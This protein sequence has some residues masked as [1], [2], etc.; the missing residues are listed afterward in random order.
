MASILDPVK[1]EVIRLY[2][3]GLTLVEVGRR[4]GVTNTCVRNLLLAQGVQPRTV[5]EASQLAWKKP[6]RV[7]RT[8][9]FDVDQ[10]VELYRDGLDSVEI[11][12]RLGTSS[13]HVRYLLRR[14][15]VEVRSKSEAGKIAW[16]ENRANGLC[17]EADVG[18]YRVIEDRARLA[19]ATQLSLPFDLEGQPSPAERERQRR[20]K[21]E[22][23]EKNREAY[24]RTARE[25]HRLLR[26][27]AI[28]A[29]GGACSCCGSSHSE[30]LAIDHTLG[31]GVRHRLYLGS[32]GIGGGVGFYR[33]LK[34][35]GYPPEFR[36]M[37]HNCNCST[38][39][40]GY[41]PHRESH[42]FVPSCEHL[43]G[44][45]LAKTVR[46]ARRRRLRLE[47]V[48]GYGGRC[49]CCGEDL[50]EFLAVD[51]VA[52]DGAEHRR[53]IGKGSTYTFLRQ[54]VTDGFPERYRLL[55][56]NCN[57]SLGWYGHCP[58]THKS[59]CM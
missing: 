17:R 6:S 43:S 37:C 34:K 42:P 55:C 46:Q 41:C 39:W 9:S 29:Y 19:P 4:F 16:E 44:K 5:G 52:G 12:D 21:H 23:Y 50:V 31:G 18:P 14:S 22:Y 28:A 47:V 36:L 1:D 51:H 53:E 49:A 35:N 27:E 32:R 7:A 3:S 25:R 33:W 30:F 8:S 40:Y 20:Y 10:V 48:D 15:G 54:I 59:R 11:G 24:R 58:H 45:D 2:L 38:S 57:S 13:V 56:H 26:D